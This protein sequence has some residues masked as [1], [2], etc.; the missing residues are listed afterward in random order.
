MAAGGREPETYDALPPTDRRAAFRLLAGK[1]YDSLYSYFRP[2]GGTAAARGRLDRLVARH[3][4]AEPGDPRVLLVRGRLAQQDR[5]WA[6]AEDAYAKFLAAA[7]KADDLTGWATAFYGRAEVGFERGR[8]PE[9]YRLLAPTADPETVRSLFGALE[10][11]Y[12]AARDPAGYAALLAEHERRDPADPDLGYYR[13]TA[14]WAA[15]DYAKAA[16]LYRAYL[17]PTWAGPG[18]R[19]KLRYAWYG[20]NTRGAPERL[21]RALLRAGRAAEVPVVWAKMGSPAG[22]F[23]WLRVAAAAAAGDLAGAVRA[24]DAAVPLGGNL[25]GA[26]TDPDVGPIVRSPGFAAFRAA[27]PEPPGLS[28]RPRD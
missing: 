23:G 4:A 17:E 3:A 28:L 12:D 1:L 20:Y 16:D 26:Y 13:A 18:P 14:K 7:R 24:V 15:K 22:P 19:P 5:D 8:G 27:R 10:Q 2:E 11:K 6:A 25:A 21:V 9:T